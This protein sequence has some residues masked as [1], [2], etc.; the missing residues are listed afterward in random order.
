MSQPNE[1]E[2][3]PIL[4]LLASHWISMLGTALVTL[5]GIS[6]LFLLPTNLTGKVANPYIGLLFFIIVPIIF[7]AGLAFIPVGIY[8]GKRRIAAQ[9]ETLTDRKVAIRRTIV[10]FAVMTVANVIIGSQFTYRAVRQMDT[11]QFCGQ[12]CHVMNP[13]FTA[14]QFPPHMGVGCADC[15]IAPGAA[16][17]FHAKMA[18]T[19][20]LFAVVFNTFPRPIESAMENNKLVSSEDSCE[21]CHSR[22]RV[23]GPKLQVITKFKDDETNT[24]S[25]TVLMMLVGGGATGGIHG[26]HMGPGVKIRYAAADKKRQTIPWVEYEDAKGKR[27]FTAADAKADAIASMPTFEMQCVDCHNRAAHSF[28]LADHAVDAALASGAIPTG[29]PYVKKTALDLLKA[30]YK[31]GEEA[32]QKITAG[33]TDFYTG[34]YPDIAKQRGGDIQSAGKAIAGIYARNVFPDLKVTWGTYPNNLGHTD[35][36][37]CFRCHDDAH[38]TADK[39]TISQDCSTCHNSLAVEEAAPDVLKTLGL[40]DLI[41]KAQKQ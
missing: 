21:Q 35:Y 11:A 32:E 4:V 22:E 16:G 30:D 20:Q 19:N 3:R 23:V 13:E 10:F 8:F 2:K 26:A 6:W 40:A 15:H 33:L 34:K 12:T 24:R 28:E 37:G 39:K 38:A 9:V 1:L 14:H 5:A 17:W 29:L 31:T 7:F 27:T 18:G 25:E 41:A 36:P